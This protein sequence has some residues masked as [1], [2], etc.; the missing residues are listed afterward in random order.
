MI[1][2]KIMMQDLWRLK[3]SLDDELPDKHKHEW[4]QWFKDVKHLSSLEIPR[5]Y[6]TPS[7]LLERVQIHVFCDS[8][9]QA[10]GAVAYMKI[11]MQITFIMAKG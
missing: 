10:Y 3:T 11:A 6:I 4:L 1:K 2:A 8:S 9:Q 5:R 7:A